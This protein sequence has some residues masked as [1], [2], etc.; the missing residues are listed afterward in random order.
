MY[1]IGGCPDPVHNVYAVFSGKP[2]GKRSRIAAL[3]IS[4]AA[5]SASALSVPYSSAYT[6]SVER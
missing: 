3:N 2:L 4:F 5:Q 1:S 6:R